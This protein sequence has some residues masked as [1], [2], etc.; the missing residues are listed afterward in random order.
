MGG[1]GYLCGR[2]DDSGRNSVG[3]RKER[4]K[5]PRDNIIIF[6]RVRA[7]AVDRVKAAPSWEFEKRATI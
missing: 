2:D 4:K 7:A 1:G 3:E 6:T 5:K